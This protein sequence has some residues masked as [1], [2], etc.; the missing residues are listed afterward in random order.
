VSD[1]SKFFELTIAPEEG[2]STETPQPPPHVNAESHGQR[3]ATENEQRSLVAT[4]PQA[5]YL[6]ANLPRSLSGL[7]AGQQQIIF[8]HPGLAAL[9]ANL[10]MLEEGRDVAMR[11]RDTE[12]QKSEKTQ[13]RAHNAE[14]RASNA[15]GSLRTIQRESDLRMLLSNLGCVLLGLIPFAQ[16]KLQIA[17]SIALGSIGAVLVLGAWLFGKRNGR[18]K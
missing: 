13:E 10:R 2:N 18:H 17:G 7:A 16:E 15:E 4:D 3:L 11:E 8:N 6:G 9:N 14:L 12:R 5:D 1:L